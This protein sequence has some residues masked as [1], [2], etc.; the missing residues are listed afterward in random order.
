M[1]SD[2][3]ISSQS[4]QLT[5]KMSSQLHITS[6]RKLNRTVVSKIELRLLQDYDSISSKCFY[7]E[8]EI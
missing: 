6:S 5:K 8:E 3:K 4:Y 7:R 2:H 1:M